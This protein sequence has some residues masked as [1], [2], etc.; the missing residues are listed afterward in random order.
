MFAA[1]LIRLVILFQEIGKEEEF[2]DDK[3]DKQLYQQDQPDPF[4]PPRHAGEAL[5]VEPEY[6]VKQ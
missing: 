4:T 6:S 1:L 3:N 2:Q 5:I